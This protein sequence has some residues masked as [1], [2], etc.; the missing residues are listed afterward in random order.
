MPIKPILLLGNPGLYKISEEV[1]KDELEWLKPVITDLHDTLMD[2]R[3]RHKTGR[4]I[5]APQ[6]GVLKRLV[7][8][9]VDEPIVLINPVI[10]SK[11]KQ[12]IE[13]WDECMSFPEIM[14]KVRRHK[15]IRVNYRNL[16]WIEHNDL[17]KDDFS[18]LLQHEI[19]HL[20]GILA[21]KRAIDDRSFAL[22]S[23]RELAE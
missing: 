10:Y 7:Y 15:S 13:L 19:D 14:V 6:I 22:K 9:H 11:S 12:T 17:F 4:A 1:R 2:F 18:E 20:E 16:E 3:A 21:V 23:Q 5:A 8:V